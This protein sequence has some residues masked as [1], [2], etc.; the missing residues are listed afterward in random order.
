MLVTRQL[1]MS[2][3]RNNWSQTCEKRKKNTIFRL[4]LK[5]KPRPIIN[6]EPTSRNILRKSTA[7]KI[8]F[9][10]PKRNPG[11]KQNG[12]M[13]RLNEKPR[14]KNSMRP[15][16]PWKATKRKRHRDFPEKMT[17]KKLVLN[18]EPRG[19]ACQGTAFNK[20]ASFYFIY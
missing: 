14:K 8:V 20:N 15:T 16:K 2:R 11:T 9:C 10:A 12:K 19:H 5:M 4:W 1:F 18:I 7:R 17:L 6:G 3:S 13:S